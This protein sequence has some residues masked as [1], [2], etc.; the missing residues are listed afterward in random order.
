MRETKAYCDHCGKVLNE[1]LDYC[2]TEI[3]AKSWFKCD[4]CKDCIDEL[5]QI[6]LDFCKRGG[7]E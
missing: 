5:D 2:D 3:E 6:V 1:K 4:L 7:A